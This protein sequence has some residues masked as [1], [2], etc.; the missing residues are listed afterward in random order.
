[1]INDSFISLEHGVDCET[2]NFKLN[3]VIQN[4]ET[5]NN[6]TV[7][8]NRS[9][10]IKIVTQGFDIDSLEFKI[11]KYTDELKDAKN[12][13]IILERRLQQLE[14]QKS[15]QNVMVNR[16]TN[17]I[18]R[19]MSIIVKME[20]SEAAFQA[21]NRHQKLL[22]QR[23]KDKIAVF[24]SELIHYKESKDSETN[25]LNSIIES[26]VSSN[27]LLREQINENRHEMEILGSM[28]S[29][30]EKSKTSLIEE[31]HQK[32]I[33]INDLQSQLVSL[34]TKLQD[35][36]RKKKELPKASSQKKNWEWLFNSSLSPLEKANHF[37]QLRNEYL[38]ENDT[39]QTDEKKVPIEQYVEYLGK[40]YKIMNAFLLN[41]NLTVRSLSLKNHRF[42]DEKMKTNFTHNNLF[43]H[44]DNKSLTSNG[45]ASEINKTTILE[46]A[47]RRFSY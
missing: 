39:S 12:E 1:M 27:T 17:E 18:N 34:N 7:K 30:F 22:I 37:F 35:L 40:E 41:L 2:E 4:L 6:E 21:E 36:E 15:E 23:L 45:N 46:L 16:A 25:M 31:N 20:E 9:R 44:N 28:I 11:K 29:S 38:E 32:Q 24:D 47:G 14:L 19:L 26:L 43:I 8:Q 3:I 33:I 13:Q 42:G 10:E 5:E